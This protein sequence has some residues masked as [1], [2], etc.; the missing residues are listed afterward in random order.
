MTVRQL[1]VQAQ[2]Y[3]AVDDRAA[4]AAMLPGGGAAAF[5]SKTGVRSATDLVLTMTDGQHGKV[6]QGLIWIPWNQ[7][8]YLLAND[9]D[10]TLTFANADPTN[11]RIDLVVAR[12]RDAEAGGAAGQPTIEVIAGTPA[13]APVPPAVPAG[14]SALYQ[15]R[16]N[17][18]S[19]AGALTDVRTLL[20]TPPAPVRP[21]QTG[22]GTV[23]TNSAGGYAVN[24]PVAFPSPPVVLISGEGDS[25][26][27]IIHG[28]LR[29]S[30][31][32][33]NFQGVCRFHSGSAL[34]NGT[35]WISWTA[36]GP[37]V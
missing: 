25:G 29:T 34:A 31:T 24:F 14:A 20:V 18:G 36:I 2:S 30:I 1:W 19:S 9:A 7:S 27:I 4:V 22:S 16:Y 10:V 5:G 33:G 26:N 15:V 8:I 32:T 13:Q 11:A 37:A 21:V 12:V 23:T 17:A 3:N 35:T 28:L 6:S